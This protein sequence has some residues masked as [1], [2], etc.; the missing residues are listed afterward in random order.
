MG[1]TLTK[2]LSNRA[3][4][5]LLALFLP[6]LI[7][8]GSRL[9]GSWTSPPQIGESH[10]VER[11]GLAGRF[12][13]PLPG[14][15]ERFLTFLGSSLGDDQGGSVGTDNHITRGQRQ[16]G[17]DALMRLL[18]AFSANMMLLGLVLA[19]LISGHEQETSEKTFGSITWAASLSVFGL[20]LLA[21]EV[22]ALALRGFALEMMQPINLILLSQALS[23]IVGFALLMPAWNLKARKSGGGVD[24]KLVAGGYIFLLMLLPLIEW[25]LTKLTGVAPNSL[26]SLVPYFRGLSNYQGGLLVFIALVVGPVFEELLFRG[27]LLIGLES[28]LGSTKALLLSSILFAMAHGNIWA[29]PISFLFSL[30]VGWC[31]LKT[32]SLTT[33]IVL[34]ALWN[35]TTLCWVY[36]SI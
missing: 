27:W 11:V 25:L 30:V 36:A 9:H 29:L 22:I 26:L 24:W 16:K 13:G 15:L 35:A 7:L 17:Y 20:W 12:S 6:A 14:G 2:R 3:L 32:R 23:Y 21:S 31:A 5:G 28:S 8:L 34:H 10:F 1:G 19:P 18:I 4:I 33:S